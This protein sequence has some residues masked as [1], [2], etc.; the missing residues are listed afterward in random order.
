MI[1]K[2]TEGKY[3]ADIGNTELYKYYLKGVKPIESLSG[4]KTIG[5]YSISQTEYTTI[6][7]DINSSIIR[8]IVLENFEFKIPCNLGYISMKQKKVEFKLD[9]DGSLNTK[10]LSIDFKA[11][12]AL[13]DTDEE[14][15]KNKIKIFHTNEHTNGNRMSYWWSKKGAKTKGIKAYYFLPSRGMKR[16]PSKFL[17]DKDY[18]LAFYT[19]K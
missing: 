7:E 4:G 3:K 2:R 1:Y 12:N 8:L 11:T 6:L 17:K 9:A 16:A 14:A 19:K 5:S 18:S 15:R 13:W 10:N